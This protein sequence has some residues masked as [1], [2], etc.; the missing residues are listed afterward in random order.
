MLG[1]G[2]KPPSPPS[3]NLTQKM[4]RLSSCMLLLRSASSASASASAYRSR[5]I[6]PFA[7]AAA[8]AFSTESSSSSSS[9]RVK[10]FD[11]QLKRKQVFFF[12]LFHSHAHTILLIPNSISNASSISLL[13]CCS[14]TEL[15]GWCPQ[16]QRTLSFILLLIISSIACRYLTLPYP[17]LFLYYYYFP[18]PSSFVSIL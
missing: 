12:F 1:K 14:E 8:A 7:G 17:T 10:I 5:S 13:G 9:S 18:I 16:I 3:T 11:R 6:H 15:H 4:T 2:S